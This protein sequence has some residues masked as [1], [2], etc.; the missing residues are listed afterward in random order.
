MVNQQF[1]F[2]VHSVIA[3]SRDDLPLEGIDWAIVG[4]E[5]GPRSREMKPEWVRS[6]FRQCRATNTAF[7]F[8]QWGGVRKHFTGRQLRGKTY[9]EMPTPKDPE[10][11]RAELTAA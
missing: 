9:D 11:R 4:G 7:F 2:A 10:V 6:I 5:S 8:K 1:T 3:L